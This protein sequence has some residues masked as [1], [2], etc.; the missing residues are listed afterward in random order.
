[1]SMVDF[2]VFFRSVLQ[3]LVTANIPS[4]L[5]LS[6]LFMETAFLQ[7]IGSNKATQCHIPE[8]GIL[9]VCTADF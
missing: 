7:N 9:H 6:I 2:G 1:M 8:A 5:V 4:S 3:L